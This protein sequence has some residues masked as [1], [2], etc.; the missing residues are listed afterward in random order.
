MIV[1]LQ[2]LMHKLST[3]VS[4]VQSPILD[5]SA[6]R[7]LT[8]LS[9]LEHVCAETRTENHHFMQGFC[10][11]FMS[12]KKAVN[13]HVKM[14]K[15]TFPRYPRKFLCFWKSQWL[16]KCENCIRTNPPKTEA[17][18]SAIRTLAVR[19]QE[20][21]TGVCATSQDF[22]LSS[23][24]ILLL[25]DL[26]AHSRRNKSLQEDVSRIIDNFQVVDHL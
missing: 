15:M 11:S 13:Q 4:K 17:I 26:P 18:S 16:K 12:T 2:K 7:N 1:D 6:L 24:K 3:K 10:D 8:P 19:L 9:H 14:C 25:E 21:Y 5:T 23:D 20:F 22:H